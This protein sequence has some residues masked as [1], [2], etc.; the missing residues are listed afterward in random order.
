MS[1]VEKTVS[2]KASPA[3]LFD[4]ISDVANHP[5]FIQAL[6][7]VDHLSGD[8]KRPGASWRWEFEMAGVLIRGSSETVECRENALFRFRTISGIQSVFTYDIQP[9]GGQ[10]QL[11]IR[12]EYEPPDTVLAKA[13]DRTVIERMNDAEGDAAIRNLST[14]FNTD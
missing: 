5:A 7:S 6:R 13:L 4:Y 11:T 1:L 14:I 2:L 3:A 9:D 8:P 10:S 12:V